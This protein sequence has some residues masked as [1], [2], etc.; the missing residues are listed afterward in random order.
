MLNGLPIDDPASNYDENNPYQ[1]RDPRLE[2]T[3]IYDEYTLTGFDG[4]QLVIDTSP[5]AAPDGLNYSS[6]STPTGYYVSKFYDPEA[7]SQTYSGLNL[8]LIRYAEVLLTYAEAKIE[9]G[10]FTE[11][12]WNTTI[13]AIR[14]RAGLQGQA[15]EYP[16]SDQAVLRDILR[17]ERRIELAFEA[18]H[19]FFDIRRWRIAE[20]VLN[21]WA[22]GIP[23]EEASG[24]DGYTRVDFRTFDEGKH[25]LWPIPLSEIEL[26]DNLSPNNPNW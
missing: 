3:I 1:N 21:G 20:D 19:R 18:G 22:H 16:G 9:L 4:N 7:R 24:E 12:D 17:T 11:Q 26:N 10:T 23:T 14:E 25:Y 5:G 6:N 2:A 15:L 13:R 8:I